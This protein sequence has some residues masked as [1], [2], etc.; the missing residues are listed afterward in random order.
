[1][2]MNQFV[3][4]SVQNLDVSFMSNKAC[5]ATNWFVVKVE[6]VDKLIIMEY[7]MRQSK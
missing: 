5:N 2:S 3:T 4:F 7:L 6:I 1:M